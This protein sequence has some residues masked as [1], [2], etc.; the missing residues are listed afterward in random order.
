MSNT[1]LIG[2]GILPG[3]ALLV[4]LYVSGIHLPKKYLDPWDRP[5]LAKFEDPRVQMIACGLLAPSSHN[6]Q[7]WKAHLDENETTFSLFVDAERPLPEVDPLS[8]QIMVSQGT[9]L[10]NVRIGAEHLGYS[11]NIDL[12]PDGEIDSEGSA[13]SMISK[14]VARVSVD[15]GLGE[16]DVSP[17]Y[18]AVFER[19]TV[20]TPYL[21]HPLTDDQVERLQSLG[22]EPGVK[23]LIFQ[24]EEDLEE[25]RDLAVRGVEIESSLAG[26]MRE[27]GELFRINE[28]QKNRDRDGL[29][30]DSQG[31]PAAL[32]LL[33]EGFG[34]IVPLG[35]E[36]MAEMWRKGEVDRI[37]RTPAYA[38][39]ITEGNSR[40]GQVKAGMVYERLQLAGAG[41]GVSMQPMSQVLEEYPEMGSLYEEVHESFAGDNRTIQ[42][43]VR[44]GVAEKEVGHSP[45]RD[46]LDLLV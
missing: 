9:F 3:L 45:R 35:D 18:E 41:L 21:D 29:T 2:I 38:M 33:V 32:Q 42:M 34:T 11:P 31:M 37:G 26:P 23:I 5:H 40:T 36:K 27:S 46:V 43:L 1:A 12:F 17:L 24:D 22:D 15:L 14:P 44:M 39:I 7:P 28:R 6:I 13:S 30:L 16:N 25:I 10:E 20:R 4:M 8:R 19:V